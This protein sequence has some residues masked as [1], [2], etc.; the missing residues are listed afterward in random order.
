MRQASRKENMFEDINNNIG[1]ELVLALG[2]F[3]MSMFLTPIYTNFAYKH[4][5]WKKQ[6]SVTIEKSEKKWA[7]VLA[8]Q[9]WK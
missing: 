1:F 7:S 2:G 5:L 8:L 9:R 6:K 3:L 4:K